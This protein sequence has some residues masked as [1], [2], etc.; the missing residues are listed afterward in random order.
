MR[1]WLVVCVLAWSAAVWA[2]CDTPQEFTALNAEILNSPNAPTNTCI[3][4]FLVA[5]QPTDA[6][7]V[8]DCLNVVRAGNA[9]PDTAVSKKALL[10]AIDIN[11][12]ST[13]SLQQQNGIDL[14][15]G[16]AETV[17]LADPPARTQL[18]RLFPQTTNASFPNL[19]AAPTSRAALIALQSR[20]GSRGESIC[21]TGTSVTAANVSTAFGRQP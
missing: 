19:V 5:E 1:V 7:A 16:Q 9:V 8:A 14:F 2:A 12:Y 11:E 4:P 10:L 17:N 21:G 20:D 18:A 3:A 13:M 15:I 6:T